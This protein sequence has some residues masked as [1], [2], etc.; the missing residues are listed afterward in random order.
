MPR[1]CGVRECST[2]RSYYFIIYKYMEYE[3]WERIDWFEDYMVWT[4]GNIKSMRDNFWRRRE[5]ILS[6][7]LSKWYPFV[8]LYRDKKRNKILVNRLIA[9]VFHWLDL[10]N[11]KEIACHKDDD[12]MN[13]RK[14]NLFI[15]TQRDNMMDMIKKRRNK[16][17]TVLQFNKDGLFIKKWWSIIEVQRGIWVRANAISACCKGKAKSSWGFIWKY[18]C[19]I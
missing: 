7:W 18:E 9:H 6:I 8:I 5:K 13:N 15:W 12:P 16:H 11:P 4:F 19:L 1:L 17:M 2:I 14:D 10:K 3:E